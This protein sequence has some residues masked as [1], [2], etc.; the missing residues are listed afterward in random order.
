MYKVFW[1][2]DALEELSKLWLK[3][4]PMEINAAIKMIEQQLS[5]G[6]EQ[7]GES[8]SRASE[9]ILFVE[10]LCIYFTI[11]YRDRQR[12]AVIQ[13]VWPIYKNSR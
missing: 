7:A 13:H 6:A 1:E 3:L 8:R 11:E 10:P 5:Q 12:T 4:R 9:R 2:E